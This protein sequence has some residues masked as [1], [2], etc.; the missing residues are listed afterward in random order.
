MNSVI[1]IALTSYSSSIKLPSLDQGRNSVCS[2]I[3]VVVGPS[4]GLS[5][6]QLHNASDVNLNR[7]SLV[8]RTHY[9]LVGATRALSDS[10][11]TIID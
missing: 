1:F 8:K 4:R 7:R 11:N 3:W 5:C 2:R 9:Y 10:K 6:V